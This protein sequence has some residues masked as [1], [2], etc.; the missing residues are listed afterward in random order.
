MGVA[1][2]PLKMGTDFLIRAVLPGLVA[3][4]AFFKPLIY[5]LI[6]ELW[7]NLEFEGKLLIWLLI[8]FAI[9]ISF[10]LFDWYIY[11]FFEG[12]RFWP[13]CLRRWKY[14]RI[15]EYFDNLQTDLENLKQEK[16][17]ENLSYEKQQEISIEESELKRKIR[18]FPP[19]FTRD[20]SSKRHP[21]FPTRF[22]NV[23]CD[24]EEYSMNNY[25]M[26]MMVFWN[27]LFHNLS[28]ETREEIK[29][30]G[31][32]ADLCVYLC[33]ASFW[34]IFLGPV[35]LLI[36]KKSWNIILNYSIPLSS[37]VWLF[38]SIIAF[39]ILYELSITQ[40]KSYGRLIKSVFDLYRGK[41]AKDLGFEIKKKLSRANIE[42]EKALWEKYFRFYLDYKIPED[43]DQ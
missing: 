18:E 40:H 10:M 1:D 6:Y 15:K 30:Q 8:G 12:L 34:S 11:Q 16:K 20:N 32:I 7:N 4:F 43:K 5:P 19:D 42:K 22:G 14:K 37:F 39:K 17:Q 33:F 41:L 27:H 36:Q 31:A 9:G 28:K 3:F 35:S 13:K 38:L 24:Y 2:I 23:L 21:V 25:G 29:L 26:H